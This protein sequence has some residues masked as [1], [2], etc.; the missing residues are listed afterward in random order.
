MSKSRRASWLLAV[1]ALLICVAVAGCGSTAGLDGAIDSTPVNSGGTTNSGGA[2]STGKSG[3]P[4]ALAWFQP[5]SQQVG[6]IWASVNGGAAHQVTHLPASTG[7]CRDD[8]HWSPPVFSPDLSKIVAARGGSG[9]GNGP[10]HGQIYIINATTGAAVE[11]PTSDIRLSLRETGWVDNATIW[12]IKGTQLITYTVGGANHIVGALSGASVSDAVLR[13]STLFYTTS[14][15]AGYQL[16]RY[17]MASHSLLGG[18]IHLGSIATCQCPRGDA[19]TPGFDVSADGSHVVYQKITPGGNTI[20]GVGSSEFFYANADSSGTSRIAS[21]ASAAS[22]VKMQLSPNGKLVAVARAEPSPNSVF[23]ASVTSAGASGDLNLRFYELDARGYP[24]WKAD[25]VTFWAGTLD[26]D[27]IRPPTIGD[28]DEFNA[29]DGSS[30]VGV[31]G[32]ANP[33]YT[34]GA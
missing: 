28:I 1:C 17:D 23:S 20:E 18:V 32:G 15:A 5:D 22:F 30:D 21:A 14:V 8:S 33:W 24:V 27:T 29:R 34:I 2:P 3:P 13:G 31:S 11:V 9:C 6:Q 7:A 19:L 25:S 16:A 12:W 10:E 4:H 26:L